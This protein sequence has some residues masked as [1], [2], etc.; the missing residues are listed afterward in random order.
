[1]GNNLGISKNL[2]TGEMVL[3]MKEDFKSRRSR[4]P[5]VRRE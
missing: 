3:G 4:C 5:P 1:M 2:N